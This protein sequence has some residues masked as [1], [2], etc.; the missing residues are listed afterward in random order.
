MPDLIVDSLDNVEE[1]IRSAYVESEGQFTLDPDRYAD[2]KKQGLL[3]KNS[4]LIGEQ[5]RLKEQAAKW[6]RFKDIDPDALEE[7]IESRDSESSNAGDAK[8]EQ[9][10]KATGVNVERVKQRYEAQLKEREDEITTQKQQVR[11]F[12]IWTP[13]RDLALKMKNGV[14]PDRIDAFVKLM[15]TDG[16]FDLNDAGQLVFKESDGYVSDRTPEK[17]FE[18][19]REEYP[20]F[21][22]ASGAAGSGAVPGSNGATHQKVDYSKLSPVERINAARRK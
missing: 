12:S 8:G 2:M 1:S 9:K 13:V 21:F 7:F 20:F 15:R 6:E 5:K 14:L 18:V 19:L 3:R 4:E 11:E 22:A 17:A 10:P 16:R